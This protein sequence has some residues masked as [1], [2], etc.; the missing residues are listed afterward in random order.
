[1]TKETN[2]KADVAYFLIVLTNRIKTIVNDEKKEFGVIITEVQALL[3]D[4][5]D[6]S[7]CIDGNV[8]ASLLCPSSVNFICTNHIGLTI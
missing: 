2:T 4:C 7:H 8:S 3:N 1:M 6:C 5:N